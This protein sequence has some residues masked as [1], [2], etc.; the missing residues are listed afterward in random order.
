MII[1]S[2]GEPKNSERN[3]LYLV[4]LLSPRILIDLTGGWTHV[5]A[6]VLKPD[7]LELLKSSPLKHRH[8]PTRN[9]VRKKFSS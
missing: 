2:S 4:P 9:N 5:S 1:I 3:L 7:K 8:I 6:Y